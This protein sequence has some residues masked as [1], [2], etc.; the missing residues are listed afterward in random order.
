MLSI[1]ENK[2]HFHSKT[3]GNILSENFSAFWTGDCE[4][5]LPIIILVF[6]SL[7]LTTQW[8]GSSVPKRVNTEKICRVWVQ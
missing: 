6:R 5:S 7:S 3:L 8:F 1:Y 2:L 4:G